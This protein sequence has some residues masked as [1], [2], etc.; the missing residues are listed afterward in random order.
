MTADF[1]QMSAG[2]LRSLVA[3]RNAA[4]LGA[5]NTRRFD[6]AEYCLLITR[7]SRMTR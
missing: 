6:R 7:P 1:D 3:T 5:S 2:E 4:S